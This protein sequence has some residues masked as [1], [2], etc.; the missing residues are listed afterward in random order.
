MHETGTDDDLM[1]RRMATSK[2]KVDI[3]SKAIISILMDGFQT[4]AQ[5]AQS[6]EYGL[7][8][9]VPERSASKTVSQ[10]AF[11]DYMRRSVAIGF[12][13]SVEQ[14]SGM[15]ILK[16]RHDDMRDIIRSEA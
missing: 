2:M 12:S 11:S 1:T 14:A 4:V 9:K 7:G 5:A 8:I 16:M 6:F 13:S 10:L 15:I 3:L